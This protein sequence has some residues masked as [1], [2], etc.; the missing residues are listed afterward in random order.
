M[1]LFSALSM[2]ALSAWAPA[3]KFAAASA[4]RG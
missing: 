2:N 1:P 4:M 3:T